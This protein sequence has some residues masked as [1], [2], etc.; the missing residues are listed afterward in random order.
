MLG[1]EHVVVRHRELRAHEQ[2]FDAARAEEDERRP[3]VEK[4]DPLVIGSCQP[5]EHAGSLGPD[6]MEPLYAFGRRRG[7]RGGYFRASR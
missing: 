1:P 7:N 3:E 6:A 2:R 4:A 5:A